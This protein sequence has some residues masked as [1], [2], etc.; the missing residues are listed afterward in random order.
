[1]SRAVTVMDTAKSTPAVP[2]HADILSF[3][4]RRKPRGGGI[5]HW[6]VSPT[7]DYDED[8]KAGRRLAAEFLTYIGNYPTYG[9]ATLLNLIVHDMIECAK[10]GK[11]WGGVHVGFLQEVSGFAMSTAKRYVQR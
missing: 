4:K 6:V 5:D 1:M 10:A 9:S 3:V 2:H 8:C 7:G 11:E